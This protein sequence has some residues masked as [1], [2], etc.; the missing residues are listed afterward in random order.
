MQHSNGLIKTR[1]TI[2]IIERHLN[3]LVSIV[4]LSLLTIS[5]SCSDTSSSAHLDTLPKCSPIVVVGVDGLEWDIILPMLA[6]HKLPNLAK[7]MQQGSYGKLETFFPTLSPVIW[8]TVATG[9]SHEKHGIHHFAR[10]RGQENLELYQSTDR[11]TK[12]I[13]NIATDYHKTVNSIGWWMTYP[14]ETINGVMV[15]QTN[16]NAQF[17]TRA[18][19]NIWKGSLV[20]DVP[21]QVWPAERQAEIMSIYQ[22]SQRNLA[23]I[24]K[25][26]FGTF[27]HPLGELDKRL[28]DN[29]QWAFR[30]DATYLDIALSLAAEPSQADL[31]LLYF[32]GPDVVGHRFWRYMQPD[33]FTHKP[34]TQQLENFSSIITDYYV[35]MDKAIGQLRSAYGEQAT[36]IVMSD[37]GMHAINSDRPFNPDA[38]PSNINSGDHQD[39]PPGVFFAVGPHVKSMVYDASKKALTRDKLRTICSVMDITPTLLAMMRLPIGEDM[40]GR[41]ASTIFKDDF[42]IECQPDVLVTHDTA[43]FVES[44]K[45]RANL[46]RQDQERIDQ[47]KSLG[48]IGR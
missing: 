2:A 5:C 48:Y 22:V 19:K 11:Q 8:T 30:A 16:T 39:A 20:K 12:A 33:R 21:H 32:G 18:G 43:A 31:T 7:I 3:K 25:E 6:E 26:V 46:R 44:H 47:L 27:P 34:S 14:V 36:F 42:Q 41:V 29:C 28:W 1:Y 17:D 9:K 40:E 13:W 23:S 35:Y 45:K 4:L 15:A 24:T 10:N 37:H 38:P